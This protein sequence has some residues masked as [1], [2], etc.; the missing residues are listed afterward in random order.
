MAMDGIIPRFGPPRASP[1]LCAAQAAGLGLPPARHYHYGEMIG[2]LVFFFYLASLLSGCLAMGISGGLYLSFRQDAVRRFI[3]VLLSLWM[4]V[5]MLAIQRF[6]SL[7]GQEPGAFFSLAEGALNI[8]GPCLLVYS[9]PVFAHS[10]LASGPPRALKPALLGAVFLEALLGIYGM[11]FRV[12]AIYD[13]VLTPVLFM[14]VLYSLALIL[15][16]WRGIA[17]RGLRTALKVFFFVT[18]PF[19][20]VILVELY[21]SR[22]PFLKDLDAFELFSTPLYFLV[23]NG[24]SV[25]FALTYFNRPAYFQGGRLTPAFLAEFALTKRESEIVEWL[26]QGKSYKEISEALFI[27][28]KTVDNHVQSI[29]QKTKVRSRIQLLNLVRSNAASK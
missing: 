24:L 8:A 11:V 7:S 16:N 18:I 3:P 17:L 28:F 14:S 22:I 10:A 27:S 21:R 15:A 29:Y 19:G 23:L 5:L 6:F 20:P 4:I 9:M 26:V 25:L 1:T 2:N 13:Y 12:Q